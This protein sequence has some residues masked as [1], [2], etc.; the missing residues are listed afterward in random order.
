MLIQTNERNEEP[1]LHY[2][3]MLGGIEEHRMVML[4]DPQMSSGGAALMAVRV[5]IDHGVEESKIV[6]VTCAAGQIG[7]KRLATVYPELT[8][9]VGRIEEEREP[10][11][12]EKRYFGC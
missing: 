1:E 6:V 5:L 7:L 12:M 11:W 3:K 8:V 2:L 4:L 9:I 10:R